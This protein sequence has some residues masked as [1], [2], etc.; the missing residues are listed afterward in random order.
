MSRGSAASVA[1]RYAAL[2]EAGDVIL[3]DQENPANNEIKQPGADVNYR[4]EGPT[5]Y[6][7]RPDEKEGI[8]P[9][10]R[11][12]SRQLDNA[13][14]ASSKVI[15]ESMKQTLAEN[16][17]MAARRPGVSK[18]TAQNK[19]YE[20]LRDIEYGSAKVV[21][22]VGSEWLITYRTSAGDPREVLVG[23]REDRSG[24]VSLS[25]RRKA[26]AVKVA[27][28]IG[29]I[30][31]KCGPEIQKRSKGIQ[32]RRTRILPEKGMMTF[33]VRGSSGEVYKVRIKGVRKDRRIK[34]LDKMPVKVSCS[35]KY[36]RWQGPEHWAKSNGYLYGRPV[37][38]A[39]KPN[40]KDPK[41]QHWLCKHLYAI[42]NEKRNIRFAS[43]G[44]RFTGPYRP[45]YLMG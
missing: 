16:Y 27:A 9:G 24:H 44:W 22:Q 37:G 4:A 23:G 26:S 25:V 35:C 41:G 43:G 8:V 34:A 33:D 11:A 1:L 30:M 29:E 39:S 38:T 32:Y 42:L 21:R 31:G 18:W 13:P 6:E 10:G 17:V 19:L 12:P 36:F 5:T 15:P 7:Y 3:Y 40:V 20:Q 28:R 14:P 2:R 45:D